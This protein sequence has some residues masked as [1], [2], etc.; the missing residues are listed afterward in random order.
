MVI[1]MWGICDGKNIIFT[2]QN[3]TAEDWECI[4]P[5]DFKDGTYVVEIWAMAETGYIIYTTA[6]L[7]LCDGRY[8]T[9]EMDADDYMVCISSDDYDIEVEKG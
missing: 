5:A 8:V 7:Y 6:I 9:L 1:S 3:E 4:V 2:P